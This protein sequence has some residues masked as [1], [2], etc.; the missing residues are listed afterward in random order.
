MAGGGIT[1]N[2]YLLVNEEPLPFS[3]RKAADVSAGSGGR[4][5]RLA[6]RTLAMDLFLTLRG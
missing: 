3:H 4:G 5:T 6:A 1:F 2:Q